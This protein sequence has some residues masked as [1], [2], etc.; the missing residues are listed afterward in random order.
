MAGVEYEYFQFKETPESLE[1]KGFT[2]LKA[3][4]PG[5]EL[6]VNLCEGRKTELIGVIPSARLLYA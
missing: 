5:S 1:E 2:N 4:T 3:L 6:V